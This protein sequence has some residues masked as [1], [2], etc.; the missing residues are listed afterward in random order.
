MRKPIERTKYGQYAE[1]LKGMNDFVK[2]V[3]KELCDKYPDADFF[4]LENMFESNFRFELVV[5]MME[6]AA[7]KE[8]FNEQCEQEDRE[9]MDWLDEHEG[10]AE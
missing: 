4:D 3:V 10:D 9:V 1:E 7:E 6:E 8:S 2:E 5:R